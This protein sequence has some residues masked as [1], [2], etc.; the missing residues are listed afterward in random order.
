M[1][2]SFKTGLTCCLVSSSRGTD[3]SNLMKFIFIESINLYNLKYIFVSDL[4]K[5]V[6]ESAVCSTYGALFLNCSIS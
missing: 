2:T 6:S 3:I 1:A 4:L 5:M